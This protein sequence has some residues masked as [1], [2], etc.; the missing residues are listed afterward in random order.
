M[1]MVEGKRLQQIV[2][3]SHQVPENRTHSWIEE[4]RREVVDAE[5][6]GPQALTDE[7]RTGIEG[8]DEWLHEIP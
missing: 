6:E 3:C 1:L 2:K 8:V 7:I 4:F 5:F